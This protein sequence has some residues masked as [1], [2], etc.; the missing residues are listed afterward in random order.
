MRIAEYTAPRMLKV[1]EIPAES[2]LGSDQIRVTS[3]YSGIS[4]GTEMNV[5]RG[6]APFFQKKYDPAIRLFVPADQGERWSYPIRSCD[7]G[8]WYLGY[9]VCGRV[10]EVGEN[11]TSLKVGDIVY[12]NASHQSE[13]CIDAEKA[14]KLPDSLDPRYGIFLTNLLTAFNGILDSDIKLGDNVV[15]MGQG[16]IGQLVAQMARMSGATVY[17]V[18]MI[19]NRLHVAKKNGAFEALNPAIVGDVAMKIREKTN[20]CGADIVIDASGSAKGLQQAIRIA[21]PESKVIALSWYQGDSVINFADEFHHNRITIRCS[22]SNYTRPEFAGIWPF[23]R[24]VAFC[25]SLLSQLSL[26]LLITNEYAFEDIQDAYET[27]DK[28]PENVI[29]CVLKY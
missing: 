20:G 3:L 25:V 8:V 24:K 26:G 12:I 22:Q 9:S 15:V 10:A 18:D 27:I 13:H 16:V 4:H 5:Y 1:E 17:V 29:Q 2:V 6:I 28:H 23:E 21:A 19:E 11:V 14:V 7:P